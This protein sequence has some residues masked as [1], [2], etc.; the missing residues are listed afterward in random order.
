[1]KWGVTTRLKL[2]LLLQYK[3]W[4]KCSAAK[5]RLQEHSCVFAFFAFRSKLSPFL[6][7][8]DETSQTWLS[9]FLLR[10]SILNTQ[11][12]L[13]WC[14][15]SSCKKK[16]AD[17]DK[18]VKE[19][20]WQDIFFPFVLYAT[21]FVCRETKGEL[22]KES[23]RKTVARE[24]ERRKWETTVKSRSP[25]VYSVC[26]SQVVWRTCY[27]LLKERASLWVLL[28]EQLFSRL[29]QTQRHDIWTIK[30]KQKGKQ[31]AKVI[32]DLLLR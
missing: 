5:L 26:D 23:C 20:K 17:K 7:S 11:A 1:M 4:H 28:H 24:R 10:Y 15:C 22:K 27:S 18:K 6:C 13:L 12:S 19:K 30:H 25:R 16:D 21:L 32:L 8:C 31:H 9:T 3:S 2:Q 14:S 29:S